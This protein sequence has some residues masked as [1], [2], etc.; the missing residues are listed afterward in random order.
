MQMCGNQPASHPLLNTPITTDRASVHARIGDRWIQL[1]MHVIGIVVTRKTITVRYYI[2]GKILCICYSMHA[3]IPDPA[4]CPR[5]AGVG[6][7]L[8]WPDG[9]LAER[10]FRPPPKEGGLRHSRPSRTVFQPQARSHSP[11][12][13]L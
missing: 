5:R 11:L 8:V 13:L 7:G 10:N 12:A 2:Y 4:P 3:C 9:R 6:L 1:G